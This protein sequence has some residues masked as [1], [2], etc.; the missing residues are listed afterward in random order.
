MTDSDL[1]GTQGTGSVLS[2]S[3]I[4]KQECFLLGT[5]QIFRKTTKRHTNF[6]RC[7]Y[8]TT[9]GATPGVANWPFG[10][11]VLV[12]LNPQ[13]MGD[14]LTNMYL[15]CTLPE[16]QDWV[17]F[18]TVYGDQPGRGI[19]Q[20]ATFRVD[21]QE[22]E[23]IYTDWNII[24]DELYLTAEQKDAMKNL[25]NGG[26]D[27]GTLPTSPIK[28][29]PI[30]LYVP[31]NFFFS[32]NSETYFPVC[33]I[34]QQHIVVSLTFN[35]VQFFSNTH[36]VVDYPGSQSQT[37][38]GLGSFDIVC[39]QII[40]TPEERISFQTGT[41]DIL[42]ETVRPQPQLQIPNGGVPNIKN[43]LVPSIPVESFH[44]FLRKAAFEQPT[45]D[46]LNRF[47]YSDTTSYS[48]TDQ[49]MSPIMSDAVFFINGAPQLGFMEDS[50]RANPQS[51]YYFKY[52]EPNSASLSSPTR[53]IYTYTF[54]LHPTAGPLT[55]AID[56]KTLTADKNFINMS[57]MNTATDTYVMNMFYL[58]LVTLHFT[59]GFLTILQ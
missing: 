40:L 58:G 42:I 16:L 47:N 30:E 43:F 44:W 3:A 10:Q 41:K 50:S 15:R 46:F 19:L 28:S 49:A 26:Q 1:R 34:L 57:L 56:F 20:K 32:N 18:H 22:I 52:L 29:G 13:Q 23:T 33:A 27:V 54:A 11:T 51:S 7:Q 45:G 39:E 55:G 36:T 25:V 6:S 53:N 14:L 48:V 5:D 38:C 37:T 17:E 31:L 24:R 21:T 35:P 59:G 4:G 2:L 8:S 9:I 12:T